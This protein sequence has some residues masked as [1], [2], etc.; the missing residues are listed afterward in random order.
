[1]CCLNKTVFII[2]AG[3]SLAANRQ[4]VGDAAEHGRRYPLIG[5]LATVC[6]DRPIPPGTIEAGFAA[7]IEA[8]QHGPIER[9]V[10]SIQLADYYVGSQEVNAT[11]SPYTRLLDRFPDAQFLSFNYDSLLELALVKGRAWSPYD[12]FGVPV[13]VGRVDPADA[14][15]PAPSRNLV[16]HL[17]G[18]PLLYAVEMEY[19]TESGGHSSMTWMKRRKEPRFLFDPDRLGHCFP[20]WNRHD[21]GLEYRS[22]GFRIIAPVPN[23]AIALS[24]PFVRAVYHRADALIRSAARIIAVGYRFAPCDRS[25]FGP[26]VRAVAA[27]DVEMQI[28]SPDAADVAHHLQS[29]RPDLRLRPTT[30]TYEEWARAGCP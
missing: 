28:V 1:V 2:G 13:E 17:H 29:E 21:P 4:F 18:T 12:G 20:R 9:L 14:E 16:L 27:A 10:L 23:K 6:F 5:D 8:G 26:L 25:S 19:R 7:A 24:K 11:D 15:L 30:A 3:F 22:P